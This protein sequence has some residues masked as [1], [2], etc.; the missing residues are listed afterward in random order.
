MSHR[1]H[2]LP[3]ARCLALSTVVLGSIRT[4][5]L[6]IIT[7]SEFRPIVEARIKRVLESS[8]FPGRNPARLFA[9][10]VR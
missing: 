10:R 9:S 8:G 6:Y 5:E 3:R 7:H 2:A 4:D 1:R